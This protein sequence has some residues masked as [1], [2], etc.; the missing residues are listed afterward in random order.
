[1]TTAQTL[2]PTVNTTSRSVFDA[3]VL[4]N[5]CGKRDHCT[6][7]A[8][9]TPLE[10]LSWQDV[11]V[12]ANAVIKHLAASGRRTMVDDKGILSESLLALFGLLCYWH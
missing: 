2:G 10:V 8:D 7:I 4:N 12:A 5:G 9:L 1:M 6:L 11:F 3:Y